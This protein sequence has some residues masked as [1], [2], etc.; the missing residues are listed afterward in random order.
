[1]AC[2]VQVDLML[3]GIRAGKE[4]AGVGSEKNGLVRS[5]KPEEL[6]FDEWRVRLPP[7]PQGD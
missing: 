2:E 4:V 5:P 6:S 7:A 1:M 3:P